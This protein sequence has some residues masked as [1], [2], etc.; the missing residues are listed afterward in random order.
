MAQS[1]IEEN[2]FN[3]QSKLEI[4]EINSWLKS[5]RINNGHQID[6]HQNK[7]TWRAMIEASY[8]LALKVPDAI[9]IAKQWDQ[10]MWE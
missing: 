4:K 3:G 5:Q 1:N 7:K 9:S 6:G 8:K 2:V 10:P